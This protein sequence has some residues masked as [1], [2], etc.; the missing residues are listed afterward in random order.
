MKAIALVGVVLISIGLI[1]LILGGI[2]Y[3]AR[4]TE[5]QFGPLEISARERRT[6]VSPLAGG[7]AVAGGLILVVLGSRRR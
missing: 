5:V 6:L 1:A 3:T 2:P 4:Q 7:V